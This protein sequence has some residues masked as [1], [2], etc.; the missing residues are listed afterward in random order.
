MRY[1]PLAIV[2]VVSFRNCLSATNWTDAKEPSRSNAGAEV[3]DSA[4]LEGT[5]CYPPA[6]FFGHGGGRQFLCCT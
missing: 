1:S 4:G 3:R 6:I 5:R 2:V